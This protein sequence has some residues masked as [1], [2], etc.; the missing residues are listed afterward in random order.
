MTRPYTVCARQLAPDATAHRAHLPAV[1][2]LHTVQ[3]ACSR[4]CQQQQER[5]KVLGILSIRVGE[6]KSEKG[7]PPFSFRYWLVRGG[8]PDQYLY[9]TRTS[10]PGTSRNPLYTR[11]RHYEYEYSYH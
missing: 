3:P 2:K 9:G 1:T 11:T 5:I 8:P 4:R 10:L 6:F 7:A